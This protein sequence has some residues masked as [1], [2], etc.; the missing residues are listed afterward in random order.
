MLLALFF[1]LTNPSPT[2]TPASF[3][4]I[5]DISCADAQM[6]T[7]A[8]WNNGPTLEW[9]STPHPLE[10]VEPIPGARVT[11]DFGWRKHPILH[12]RKQ[13]K[14]IDYKGVR[15]TPVQSSAIGVVKFAGRRAGYGKLIVIEHGEGLE[16]RYA[17]LS[18][19]DV[20]ENQLVFA[21]QLVGEVGATGKVTGPHLHFELRLDG[22]A[23]DPQ[24]AFGYSAVETVEMLASR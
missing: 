17:H 8:A 12:K 24:V 20:K 2:N 13:H 11:S 3:C 19:I 15:G 22:K 21:G 4:A 7:L 10:F 6:E 14:G 16:T 5:G 1:W 23:L 18:S 9:M